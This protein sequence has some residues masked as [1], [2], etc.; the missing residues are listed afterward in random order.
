MQRHQRRSDCSRAGIARD[1]RSKPIGQVCCRYGCQTLDKAYG[2]YRLVIGQ[3]DLKDADKENVQWSRFKTGDIK[4]NVSDPA[5][6][7]PAE[8]TRAIDQITAAVATGRAGKLHQRRLIQRVG[9]A[10]DNAQQQH[11]RQQP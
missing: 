5:M 7:L 4:G 10:H 8:K 2:N 3:E 1:G 11:R 6:F 9:D